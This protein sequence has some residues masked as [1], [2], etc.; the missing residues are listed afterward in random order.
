ME[1]A[2]KRKVNK[3][4]MDPRKTQQPVS[5]HPSSVDALAH[6]ADPELREEVR[7][8]VKDRLERYR[9][10]GSFHSN[11]SPASRYTTPP[12]PPPSE[13]EAEAEDED[14]MYQS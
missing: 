10:E 14:V 2:P 4:K 8:E 1:I 12:P 11:G 6:I 5:N 9:R 7:A 3:G 13:P